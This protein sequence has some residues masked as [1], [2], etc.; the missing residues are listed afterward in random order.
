MSLAGDASNRRYLRL[1]DPASG[2]RRIVMD[3]PPENG[4]DVRPFQNIANYLRKAGLSAPEIYA[5]NPDTGFLLL[6]DLGDDLFARLIAREGSLEQP[7]YQAAA[8]VLLA[9]RSLPAPDLAEP[10]AAD[11]AV[12]TEIAF[13]KYAAPITAGEQA[14]AQAEFL[15]RFREILDKQLS[16]QSVLALRDYHAEN[17]IWLPDRAG[18]ARVGL[19]DFQDAFLCHPAYDLV[20][21]LQDAR[22]DVTPETEAETIRY[23]IAHTGCDT[24][25]FTTAYAVLGAQRNLRILG[26]FGRLCSDYGKPQY[27]DLVL[28]VWNH[29]MRDLDHPALRP[30]AGLLVDSLPE[31]TPEN[32]SRLKHT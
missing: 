31:P 11:L 13:H 23:Y 2:I 32:L 26:V 24:A 14:P 30:V 22:R 15:V 10:D 3:A 19:L 7:L 28:R 6:E 12:M 27:L 4:E 17:L 16:G 8:D 9:L 29:L 20:S 1:T 25:E 5:A 18:P 21:L